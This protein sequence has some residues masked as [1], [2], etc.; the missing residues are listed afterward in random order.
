MSYRNYY[1]YHSVES[2]S[3]KRRNW[4]AIRFADCCTLVIGIVFLAIERGNPLQYLERLYSDRPFTASQ[5]LLTEP[6]IL[7]LYLSQFFFP[8]PSRLSFCHD[9]HV[10]TSLIE[11]WTTLPAITLIL[12]AVVGLSVVNY[13][14][15]PLISSCHYYFFFSIMALNRRYYPLELV[16]EHRNYLPSFFLFCR[17]Q[18][19]WSD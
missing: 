5:R 6:R 8:I 17:L 18:M 12:L 15:N 7:L 13:R 16:F 1:F 2:T 9:I 4:I 3:I 11:P 19:S 14:K 10:S